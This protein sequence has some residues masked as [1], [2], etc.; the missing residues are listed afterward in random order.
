MEHELLST[1]SP[2]TGDKIPSF[3]IPCFEINQ[4]L[5]FDRVDKR[6]TSKIHIE[7]L[8]MN[9]VSKERLSFRKKDTERTITIKENK[10]APSSIKIISTFKNVN[11]F[12]Q[13][14][15]FKI[16]YKDYHNL[17]KSHLDIIDDMAIIE[18]TIVPDIHH[19]ASGKKKKTFF[20]RAKEFFIFIMLYFTKKVE[21][22]FS[23]IPLFSQGKQI[24]IVWNLIMILFCFYYFFII[25]VEFCF[26]FHFHM[27][28]YFC[29]IFEI[30]S[31]LL[32][33]ADIFLR[34]NVTIYEHGNEVRSRKKILINYLRSEFFCDILCVA[35]VIVH[36]TSISVG[37]IEF[38]ILLKV[39]RFSQCFDFIEQQYVFSNYYEGILN[40]FRLIFKI[41]AIAHFLAC[42][43]FLFS[44]YLIQ[45]DNSL[46]SWIIST[47]LVGKP[48]YAIYLNGFYWAITTLATVGYGDITPRNNPEKMFCIVVMLL[49][50]GIFAYNINRLSNIFGEISQN[51][52]EY[53]MNM[54]ILN[55]M[56]TRKKLGSELQN[57]I[58]NYFHYIYKTEN[59]KQIE[60]ENAMLN[61]LSKEIQKEIIMNSN[62]CILK[63][64]KFF[65]NN[66][67]EEFLQHLVFK[68]KPKLYSP[69]EKIFA[70]GELNPTIFFMVQGR[71]KIVFD[72]G[73]H[74][75]IIYEISPGETFGELNLIDNQEYKYICKCVDFSSIYCISRKDFLET[76]SKFPI[77][78]EKFV[79]IK[80]SIMLYQKYD[81]LYKKCKLCKSTFHPTEDCNFVV[82]QSHKERILYKI[83]QDYKHP[84]IN[85]RK[86]FERRKNKTRI[87]YLDKGTM[88]SPK[89]RRSSSPT[90]FKVEKLRTYRSFNSGGGDINLCKN[91][92]TFMMM[93]SPELE[94]QESFNS[95]EKINNNKCAM[96]PSIKT[97]TE[98]KD[99]GESEL[100][101]EDLEVIELQNMSMTQKLSRN[102]QLFDYDFEECENFRFYFPHNN[103]S[104]IFRKM[105]N[106]TI[107]RLS[108]LNS[109]SVRPNKIKKKTIQ[110]K[111]LFKAN[112]QA[113]SDK[114]IKNKD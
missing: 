11:S 45:I 82:F 97:N 16:L 66:F 13:K 24:F 61:K 68:M 102:D 90:L 67:S 40:I 30:F 114:Y 83:L 46:D 29:F 6:K 31:I 9:Q 4:A 28:C 19:I 43:F 36:I 105:H 37:I 57:K 108:S 21:K 2:S 87:I 48:W 38:L 81:S 89:T 110:G 77:D 65:C 73:D 72:N 106:A 8:R 22:V 55:Q 42:F 75:S 33:S 86:V 17:K 62:A 44:Q 39:A 32:F 78:Q 56:M 92:S 20:Q 111:R 1:D 84:K 12:I 95:S 5:S 58:R 98:Q 7:T 70:E 101:L 49:G 80:D 99:S 53:K 91:K 63:Q 50:G 14:L 107:T 25:P 96:D 26:Q 93:N 112:N 69:D 94:K 54:K 71:A 3:E 64:S 52:R 59:K 109:I 113:F 60:Q 35:G 47:D 51:S 41:L 100:S 15:K 74:E 27:E 85:R 104:N 23:L 79:M 34:F 103:I 76:L 10:K 18:N 88:S